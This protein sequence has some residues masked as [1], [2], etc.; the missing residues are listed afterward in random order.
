MAIAL[1]PLAISSNQ[2]FLLKEEQC[3]E[4]I[5]WESVFLQANEYQYNEDFSGI[6]CRKI[7][8]EGVG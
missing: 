3:V 7:D 1:F 2:F 6:R 5:R 4:A 8:F